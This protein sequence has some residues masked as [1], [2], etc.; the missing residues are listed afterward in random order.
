VPT[1]LS[2][3]TMG[4]T[5]G[6]IQ[7]SVVGMTIFTKFIVSD[8]QT[9]ILGTLTLSSLSAQNIRDARALNSTT[10]SPEDLDDNSNTDL[11]D[12]GESSRLPTVPPVKAGKS[13]YELNKAANIKRNREL[14]Q[15]LLDD[16]P[17]S[18]AGG[19]AEYISGVGTTVGEQLLARYEFSL[20]CTY[21]LH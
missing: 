8:N 21:T 13:Q 18:K 9:S 16:S 2:R 12:D 20:I 15:A 17:I 19:V 11:K 4:S 14:L 1:C 6:R 3:I 5:S 10:P 7:S